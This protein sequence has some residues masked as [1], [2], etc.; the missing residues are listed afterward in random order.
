MFTTG[1]FMLIM[2][3]LHQCSYD[4]FSFAVGLWSA[5][6]GKFLVDVVI[7]ICFDKFML[8]CAFKFSAI[9]RVNNINLV[10]TRLYHLLY[11][12]LCRTKGCFVRQYGSIQFTRI[13]IYGNKQ[14]FSRTVCALSFK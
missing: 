10:R 9:V 3:H 12:K 4:P 2:P 1:K 14:I 7:I 6:F 8:C 5:Y 13:V 11:Q